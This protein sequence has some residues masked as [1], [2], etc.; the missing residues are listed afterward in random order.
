VICFVAELPWLSL[1]PLSYYAA[2][3]LDGA[4]VRSGTP[5]QPIALLRDSLW[6]RLQAILAIG[7]GLMLWKELFDDRSGLLLL[8]HWSS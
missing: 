2:L 8:L 1:L 4:G 7:I 5:L 3:W 6:L